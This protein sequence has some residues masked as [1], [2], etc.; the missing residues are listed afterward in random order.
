M[1]AT[2]TAGLRA[3]VA[4]AAVAVAT[5]AYALWLPGAAA[6]PLPGEIGPCAGP[7]C[8]DEYPD[9]NNNDDVI[10]FDDSVNVFVGGDFDV[11]GTA[12]ES[13]GRNVVLGSFAQ[14][15]T[16][17]GA[18]YNVGIAGVG[19]RVPPPDGS[20]YLVTG[21]DLTIAAGQRL[22]AE[23]GAHSG[24]VRVGGTA[25]GEVDPDAVLDA[26]AIDEYTLLRDDL[27]A[28]SHCYAYP[29]D[30]VR[31]ATTG[32][33]QNLGYET[34]FTGDGSSA[35]QV[36]AVDADLVSGT[37]GQQALRFTGIPAGATVLVNLYGDART[38]NINSGP[39]TELRQRLLWNFPDA[40]EVNLRGTTQF[41]GSVLAG[42]QSS[43]T[44]VTMSGTNG[45]M[46]LTG[47]LVHGS[48][49]QAGSGQ[50]IHA[51]PFDGDLP[52]CDDT[53]PTSVPI[54]STGPDPEPPT[55]DE[56]TTDQP[57]TDE[58][59]T[60]GPTTDR[61]T[62]DGPTSD[63]PTSTGPSESATT[64]EPA[65]PASGGGDTGGLTRTGER[66]ALPLGIGAALAAAGAIAAFAASRR[67][68]EE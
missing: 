62:T 16:G 63:E 50:E 58:P 24:V 5:A 27:S 12:A 41:Q 3:A 1:P 36:F 23:E 52:E 65:A 54:N 21:G 9:D 42:E 44:E 14:N 17:G 53:D 67:A 48:S 11:T 7:D 37:G 56:P 2:R 10:G 20:D 6:A 15:K 28:A 46:L 4:T 57:T 22:L 38:L 61:P 8:P 66:L 33:V 55:T 60:D 47:N 64:S 68:A 32:T 40:A 45:R 31:R 18:V 29:E 35:L 43:T 49:S 25:T 19:S 39:A 59:T 30:G 13:E 34:L 26:T 51:Y